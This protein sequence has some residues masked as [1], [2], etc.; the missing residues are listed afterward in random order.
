[1]RQWQHI[2]VPHFLRA[3]SRR[4]CLL[5]LYIYAESVSVC[6]E[7]E[8]E[9]HYCREIRLGARLAWH[10]KHADSLKGC[11]RAVCVYLVADGHR[12]VRMA[13]LCIMMCM[14]AVYRVF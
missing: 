14:R 10:A 4:L 6:S 1:M 5:L 7:R 9:P 8:R 11:L 12:Y 3:P 2:Y 13:R